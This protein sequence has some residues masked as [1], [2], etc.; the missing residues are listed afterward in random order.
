MNN[1]KINN[2]KYKDTIFRVLFNN[3]KEALQ[4]YNDIYDIDYKDDTLINIVNIDDTLCT[5]RKS[6]VTFTMDGKVV[7]ILEYKY[8]INE[9]LP[10]M[11]FVYIAKVYEKIVDIEDT[12][13][14]ELV[15]IPSPKFVVLYNGKEDLKQNGKKVTE[16]EM[17]LPNAFT[18]IKVQVKVID[19]RYSSQ[20]KVVRRKDTL[21]KYSHFI[22]IVEDC[23]KQDKDV[24]NEIEKAV[25]IA[26]EQG[27]L[28]DFLKENI[29]DVCDI[30][31]LEY[32]EE[33]EDE[34]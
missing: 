33:I 28:A 2:K 13:K 26:I 5:A 17:S 14:T 27:I 10:L 12:Y 29:S 19:I 8:E 7:I 21:E 16:L 4:L 32:N 18:G 31:T 9:N 1:E 24:K 34:E 30:L 11:F 3:K 25:N 6:D 22:Q 20:N 23:R 15:K